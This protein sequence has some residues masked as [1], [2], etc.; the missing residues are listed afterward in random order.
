MMQLLLMEDEKMIETLSP[1]AAHKPFT[2]G[3]GPWCVIGRFEYL[4]AARCCHASETGSKFGITIA[5][6]ILRRLSKGSRFP[7]LLCC[8]GIGRRSCD[9]HMDHPSRLQFDDEEGK[10]G[11]KEEVGDLQEITHPDIFGMVLQEGTP[12]LSSLSWY[13]SMPHVLLNGAFADANA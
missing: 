12:V 9:T 10:Q 6:E 4:D 3:I 1:H 8:P 7:Q 5:N 13:A 2:D 11:A